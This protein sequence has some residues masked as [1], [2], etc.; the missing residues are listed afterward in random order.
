MDQEKN[1]PLSTQDPKTQRPL[2]RG[3]IKKPAFKP[4]RTKLLRPKRAKNKEIETIVLSSD[5][6]SSN[7]TDEDYAEFLSTWE[8]DEDFPGTSSFEKEESQVSEL[9]SSDSKDEGT[10]AQGKP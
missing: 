9:S 7:D 5:S 4:P 10:K 6:S 2:G 8:P 1:Q 3:R